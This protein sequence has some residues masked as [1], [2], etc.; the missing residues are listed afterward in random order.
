MLGHGGLAAYI[1]DPRAGAGCS[2]GAATGG[3]GQRQQKQ[4]QQLGDDDIDTANCLAIVTSLD[5]RRVS[6]GRCKA[7]VVEWAAVQ[8]QVL[9]VG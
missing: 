7:A 4:Q 3:Q 2:R 8:Q 6:S 9:V 1:N 5:E